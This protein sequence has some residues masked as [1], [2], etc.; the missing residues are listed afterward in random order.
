MGLWAGLDCQLGGLPACSLR[1]HSA[2]THTHTH[3]QYVQCTGLNSPLGTTCFKSKDTHC[4][5]RKRE[6]KTSVRGNEEKRVEPEQIM[7]SNSVLV[8]AGYSWRTILIHLSFTPF[9]SNSQILSFSLSFQSFISSLLSQKP[10]PF[11]S[12]WFLRTKHIIIVFN[13][14]PSWL[15]SL[16]SLVQEHTMHVVL[17]LIRPTWILR[18][19]CCI[20]YTVEFCGM[21]LNMARMH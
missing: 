1:G 14:C 19:F 17:V 4:L 11:P 5:N 3:T 2:S 21:Y 6:E 13:Q 7:R 10:L 16:S 9:H 8:L 18:T 15:F 12:G 20:F